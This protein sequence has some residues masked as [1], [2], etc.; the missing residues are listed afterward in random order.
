MSER[1]FTVAEAK[2]LEAAEG[3]LDGNGWDVE[4]SVILDLLREA[5]KSA[6][7]PPLSWDR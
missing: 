2:A 4:H 5:R 7:M 6:G 3:V 1:V